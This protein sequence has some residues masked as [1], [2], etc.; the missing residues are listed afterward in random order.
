LATWR[1]RQL[2]SHFY[3]TRWQW[4]HFWLYFVQGAGLLNEWA[5]RLHTR[6]ITVDVLDVTRCL[7]FCNLFC[8]ILFY[9][10]SG[11]NMM[12]FTSKWH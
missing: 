10:N 6:S 1:F 3:E 8:S 5:K 2:W 9:S 11:D 4:R 7:P 12:K